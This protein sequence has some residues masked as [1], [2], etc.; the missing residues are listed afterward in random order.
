MII[1]EVESS[2]FMYRF[3]EISDYAEQD[4]GGIVAMMAWWQSRTQDDKM[5]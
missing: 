3:T 5:T 4:D 1:A 2:Y